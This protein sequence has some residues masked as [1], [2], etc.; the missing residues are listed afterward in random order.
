LSANK[1]FSRI[2]RNGPHCIFAKVL[3]DFENKT[4]FMTVDLESA[5]D[6]R[7]I[8]I[9][10]HVDD[11]ADYLSYSTIGS[12]IGDRG[13]SKTSAGSKTARLRGRVVISFE[14]VKNA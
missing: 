5:H 8:T 9:E 4:D 12:R 6:W 3:G 11:S 14:N 10:L 2:H 7:K 1:T 13:S